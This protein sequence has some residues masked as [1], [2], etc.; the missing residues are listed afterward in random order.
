[1]NS[2]IRDI[3]S[4][5]PSEGYHLAEPEATDLIKKEELDLLMEKVTKVASEQAVELQFFKEI[6]NQV[7]EPLIYFLIFLSFMITKTV[8][9]LLKGS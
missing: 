7:L 2:T 9:H 1:M 6:D 8:I 5:S 4:N 3:I